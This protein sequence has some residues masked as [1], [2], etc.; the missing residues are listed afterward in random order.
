VLKIDEHAG[1]MA[2]TSP[3]GFTVKKHDKMVVISGADR[4]HHC[5]FL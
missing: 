5:I 1:T 4:K 2:K 3:S